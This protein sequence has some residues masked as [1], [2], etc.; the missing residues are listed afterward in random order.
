MQLK[1]LRI[2]KLYGNIYFANED[3]KKSFKMDDKSSVTG[4]QEIKK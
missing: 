1:V 3:N 4:K 2:Y